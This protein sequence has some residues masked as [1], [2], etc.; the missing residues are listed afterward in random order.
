MLSKKRR[1]SKS[2]FSQILSTGKRFNS[3]NF[4][5]YVAKNIENKP[6]NETK[7]SFSVSKKVKPSAVDRNRYRRIGYNAIGPLL[8]HIKNGFFL[9]F[10]FKKTQ[11]NPSVDASIKEIEALLLEAGVIE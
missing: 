11:N 8:K 4:L 1:I 10:S 7:V 3:K 5:L 9:F 2:D 6:P